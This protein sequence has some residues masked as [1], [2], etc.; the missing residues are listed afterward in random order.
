MSGVVDHDYLV[1]RYLS[2]S[3]PWM[4]VADFVPKLVA[5]IKSRTLSLIRKLEKFH[6]SNDTNLE[7]CVK[8]LKRR[9]FKKNS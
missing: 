2:T 9:W 6:L 3:V 7:N 5:T 4:Y 8:F 1:D